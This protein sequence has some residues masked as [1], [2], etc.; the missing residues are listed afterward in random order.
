MQFSFCSCLAAEASALTNIQLTPEISPFASGASRAGRKSQMPP[1]DLL[2]EMVAQGLSD[3]T[4]GATLRVTARSVL[5]WRIKL[6]IARESAEASRTPRPAPPDGV[7]IGSWPPSL[8][9]LLALIR[10]ER[11][12]LQIGELYGRHHTSVR[13]LRFAYIGQDGTDIDAEL[14]LRRLSGEET[15]ER[16]RAQGIRALCRDRKRAAQLYA[17]L[18]YDD[19]ERYEL[20]AESF[21]PGWVLAYR[22][23]NI[24]ER[25]DPFSVRL[26]S[27]YE[28]APA[29]P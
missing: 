24:A 13:Q 3:R 9:T 16:A 22:S 27:P 25:Y 2:R 7:E 11:S 28:A 6:G 19:V 5:N 10:A 17:G 26:T 14:C 21:L 12:D 29:P 15:G 8:G 4:I 1:G 23:R 18:R 20:L